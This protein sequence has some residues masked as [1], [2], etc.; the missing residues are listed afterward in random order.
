MPH[1]VTQRTI[2]ILT[3]CNINKSCHST[4]PHP[5]TQSPPHPPTS[6]PS[7]YLLIHPL[8]SP[9]SHPSPHPPTTPSTV[10]PTLQSL[11]PCCVISHN[12]TYINLVVSSFG[13]VHPSTLPILPSP[14]PP[15]PSLQHNHKISLS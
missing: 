13:S 10:L 8:T 4:P 9:S 6:H 3:K 2:T 14:P 1:V 12:R 15:L 5:P 7:T 11:P